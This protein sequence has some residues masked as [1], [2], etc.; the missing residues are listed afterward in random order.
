MNESL[1]DQYL[2]YIITKRL[3][4]STL[5]IRDCRGCWSCSMMPDIFIT[6]NNKPRFRKANKRTRSKK[7]K[8]VKSYF[9]R[10]H[11]KYHNVKSN[12]QAK[13]QGLVSISDY[14]NSQI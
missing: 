1:T 7:A 3:N 13:R 14:N 9:K 2:R 4:H 11:D 8:K 6:I 5:Y 12:K 10:R